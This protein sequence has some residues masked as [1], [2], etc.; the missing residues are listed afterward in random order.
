M[1]IVYIDIDSLRPDHLHC[2]GYHRQTSPNIDALAASGA[3]VRNLYASDS[4]CLPSRTAFFGGHFGTQTGVVN[5][6]GV[7]A[8]VQPQGA[9]RD[10]RSRAAEESLASLLTRCGYWTASVS[11]FPRRHSAYQMVY[12]FNETIDTGRGGLE[13]A[14]VIFE[15]VR[16]WLDRRAKR[17]HWFLHVNM[18]DPH[19][20]Y[21][22]PAEFGNPFQD[23]R[24]DGWLTDEIIGKQRASYGPHSAREVT[25]FD[26]RIDPKFWPWGRGEITS[27]A[28]AKVNLDGYD[29]GVRYADEY[30]GR[31][32]NI[33]ADSGVLEDTAI[34]VAADH[35]ENLGE[36]N[37]WGD[38]QT[39]DEF[40]N[41]IPGVI[42]WPGTTPP[43]TA[44]DGLYY[45]LD[46]ASTIVD[47]ADPRGSD[48][49]A[50]AGWEGASMA[51]A[52]KTGKGG[53]GKLFL[54]QGTWS[55]Q[56][57]ARWDDWILI[58]TIDT[59]I[60]DFSEWMLFNLAEDP[61]ETTNLASERPDIVR[62]VGQEI[63]QFFE[64]LAGQCPLG[65]PFK[66]VRAEGG[67]YH[68]KAGGGDW[69]LYLERLENTGRSSHAA[70]LREHGN[71]P[72]PPELAAY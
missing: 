57:S 63:N 23:A 51:D 47:L 7:C 69:A 52:L 55:L 48:L 60:K 54:S 13:N 16:G 70:W 14:D 34:I 40:T 28:D 37:I 4:P 72:R 25:H 35:G 11:P 20:P 17:D 50:R 19:T 8:D 12:G 31:I 58:H 41:H 18:W 56:R 10:F 29:C 71:S 44:V 24:I 66:V 42:R 39:A 67:P 22:T 65:D 21:D 45:H 61:H 33:L 43:G 3:R 46:L 1:R 62:A 2:C 68:A 38:H 32:V 5:H 27:L 36:L 6:G 53:R 30:V 9:A 64:G 26:S 59:G 49:M 15:E